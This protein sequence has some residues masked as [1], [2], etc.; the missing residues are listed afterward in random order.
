MSK[1]ITVCMGSSCFARGN[2]QNLEFIEGFIKENGLE[3]K[4]EL[5]G[6]RCNGNCADGPNIFI[7]G[8]EYNGVDEGKLEEILKNISFN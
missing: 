3:V 8:I 6:S 7:D 5:A 1:E 2:M 4:L